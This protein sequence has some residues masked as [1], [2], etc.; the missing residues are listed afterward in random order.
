[1]YNCKKSDC[2]FGKLL[3]SLHWSRTELWANIWKL[4]S[5]IGHLGQG[6]YCSYPRLQKGQKQVNNKRF[7]NGKCM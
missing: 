2:K 3:Y 4:S 5:Y 1:M 6:G 7:L